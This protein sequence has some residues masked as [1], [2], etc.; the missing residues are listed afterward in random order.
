MSNLTDSQYALC[1]K[2]EAALEGAANGLTPSAAARATGTDTGT[3]RTLLTWLV[4][5]Q[6]AHTNG[7]GAW[8]RYYAG[9]AS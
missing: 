7:N 9:R 5:K 4:E 2:L 6:F 1:D 3:A 8:M